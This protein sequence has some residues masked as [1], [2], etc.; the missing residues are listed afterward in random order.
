MGL[1]DP[2]TVLG[3]SSESGKSSTTGALSVFFARL[4]SVFLIM[5]LPSLLFIWILGYENGFLPF[6]G[7]LWSHFQGLISAL[8]YLHKDDILKE[9]PEWF[10]KIDATITSAADCRYR[11]P[12]SPRKQS[13]VQPSL[14]STSPA[15]RE[16]SKSPESV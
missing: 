12:S 14:P 9:T 13:Q 3:Y 11:L 10:Q 15:K 5:W 1:L 16:E 4:L 2:W 7:G 6:I 8:M